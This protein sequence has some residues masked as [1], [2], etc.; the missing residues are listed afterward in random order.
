MKCLSPIGCGNSMLGIYGNKL[1]HC[2]NKDGWESFYS[3]LINTSNQRLEMSPGAS[4]GANK[5]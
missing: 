3:H 4:E 5:P 1:K 2:L